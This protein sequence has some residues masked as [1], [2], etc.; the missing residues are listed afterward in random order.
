MAET[1]RVHASG[2]QIS[3]LMGRN[4]EILQLHGDEPDKGKSVDITAAYGELKMSIDAGKPL[5]FSF[6]GF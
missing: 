3:R 4:V 2:I 5:Y 1:V 6:L